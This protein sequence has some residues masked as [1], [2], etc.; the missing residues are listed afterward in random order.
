MIG[1]QCHFR[2][3]SLHRGAAAY[4]DVRHIPA[5]ERTHGALRL[6]RGTTLVDGDT[7][8]SLVTHVTRVPARKELVCN[9]HARE[10]TCA[11][12]VPAN[13]MRVSF[14]FVFN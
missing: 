1:A 4:S 7:T 13:A 10:C 8:G 12:G 5:G 9:A 3:E 6:P 11:V 14:W 2:R